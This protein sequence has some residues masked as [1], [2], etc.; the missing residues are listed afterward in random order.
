MSALKQINST[1]PTVQQQVEQTVKI[2]NSLRELLE[3][4]TKGKSEEESL[5][6]TRDRLLNLL[7][8]NVVFKQMGV[9]PYI[10][11]GVICELMFE[12]LAKTFLKLEHINGEVI[13]GI[14]LP[15]TPWK[16]EDGDTTQIDAVVVTNNG[17]ICVECKSYFGK[18]TLEDDHI[19]SR[20]Y[21]I[22]P[23][24]QNEGHINTI[25]YNIR[26][27]VDNTFTPHITNAVFL[28]SI[29]ELTKWNLPEKPRY[30]LIPKG[31]FATLRDM[32]NEMPEGNLSNSQVKAIST[33]F[34]NRKPT[35][36]QSVEHIENLKRY[37][38]D[39]DNY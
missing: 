38:K 19:I 3:N 5:I 10:A 39:K 36:K 28:F 29:G 31:C 9:Q 7:D 30:L 1:Q 21:N 2:E 8:K 17:I 23:W 33:Y 26:Y 11:R 18:M 32:Y 20:Y 4:L 25:G 35:V 14:Q 16:N 34:R 6:I 37:F 22:T 24:R 12:T 15:I 27:R 13:T